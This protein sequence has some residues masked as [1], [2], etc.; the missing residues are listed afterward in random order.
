MSGRASVRVER[1]GPVTTVILDRPQRRN[2]V[3]GPMAAELAEA[4]PAFDAD[5][6]AAVA[7]LYGDGGTFCAGRRP[8][9][10]RHRARQPGA[11]TATA[12]WARPGCGSPSR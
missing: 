5:P 6:D 7:V 11:G 12:R 1:D 3:D 9:G 4:F 2:A 10:G 8:Q